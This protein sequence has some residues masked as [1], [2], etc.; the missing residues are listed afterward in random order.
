MPILFLNVVCVQNIGQEFEKL[1]WYFG[2]VLLGLAIHG[3]IIL[4]LI[5]GIFTRSLPFRYYTPA[6]YLRHLHPLPTLQVLFRVEIYF[7]TKLFE[8]IETIVKINY[9]IQIYEI[10]NI[11]MG[12]ATFNS[13]SSLVKIFFLC[14]NN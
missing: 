14:Y 11:K 5:Y 12:R 1:G 3:G 6:T 4:P 13:M 2:T 7:S 10:V 8:F 9:Y